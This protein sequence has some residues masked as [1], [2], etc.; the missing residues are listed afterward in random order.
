MTFHT[1]KD[2]NSK[3]FL[4]KKFIYSQFHKTLP[5]S[6]LQMHW[7]SVEFYEMGDIS[8]GYR[9]KNNT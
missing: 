8:Q 6:S 7:I 1:D 3:H 4:G 5:I 9:I 2:L